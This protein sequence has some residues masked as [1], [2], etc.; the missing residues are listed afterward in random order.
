MGQ[1]IATTLDMT[2]G[3]LVATPLQDRFNPR[4]L[5]HGQVGHRGSPGSLAS[6]HRGV[7]SLRPSCPAHNGRVK[8]SEIVPDSCLKRDLCLAREGFFW[9]KYLKRLVPQ[10]RFELPTPSLRTIGSAVSGCCP[11]FTCPSLCHIDQSD[12]VSACFRWLDAIASGLLSFGSALVPPI[13][14]CPN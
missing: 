3:S 2:E 5:C 6:G 14:K 11:E 13:S 7:G 1:S 10:E 4:S 9:P 8:P 12:N